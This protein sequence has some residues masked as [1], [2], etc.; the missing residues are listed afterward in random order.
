M[1]STSRLNRSATWKKTVFS[2]TSAWAWSRSMASYMCLSLQL[3]AGGQVNFREPTLPDAELGLG[4]AQPVGHHGQQ[5]TL[6]GDL[7]AGGLFDILK[8]FSQPQP[9]PQGFDN[10][11]A[12]QSKGLFD[13]EPFAE[14]DRTE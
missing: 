7:N 5:G 8:G 6:V 9:F 12:S 1:R 13:C 14:A 4:I 3:L 2:T 10:Q 11:G